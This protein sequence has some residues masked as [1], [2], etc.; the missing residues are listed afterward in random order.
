VAGR[1]PGG[2]ASEHEHEHGVGPSETGPLTTTLTIDDRD[3]P[4]LRRL[5]GRSI[6]EDRAELRRLRMLSTA[7]ADRPAGQGR[8]PQIA[9]VEDDIRV[10]E[11]MLRRMDDQAG[12]GSHG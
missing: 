6:A 12:E 8:D 11:D 1:L 3:A 10:A 2:A 7:Y 5:L 4:V 9:Q